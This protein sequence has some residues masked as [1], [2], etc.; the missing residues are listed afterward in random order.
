MGSLH[1]GEWS[2]R[3]TFIWFM[4]A[5]LWDV[6]D[7]NL[8]SKLEV[9]GQDEHSQRVCVIVL[10]SQDLLEVTAKEIGLPR[11]YNLQVCNPPI[12]LD[13]CILY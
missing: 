2:G 6:F 11:L 9:N 12:I 13:R 1:P 8:T 3:K 10:E 5:W 7:R 4:K